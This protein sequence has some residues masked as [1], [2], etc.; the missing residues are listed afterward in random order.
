MLQSQE[1][2][3]HSSPSLIAQTNLIKG[4]QIKAQ[5]PRGEIESPR[6]QVNPQ[7]SHLKTNSFLALPSS[8]PFLVRRI[9]ASTDLPEGIT[10]IKWTCRCGH[11]SHDDFP[12]NFERAKTL[13][14]GFRHSK[15]LRRVEITNKRSGL[16][17]EWMLLLHNVIIHPIWQHISSDSS[18][19]GSSSSASLDNSSVDS[20]SSASG[21]N[22]P[23]LLDD[24][25]DIGAI[26]L[27]RGKRKFVLNRKPVEVNKKHF[28]HVCIDIGRI[29]SL[30]VIELDPQDPSSDQELFRRL[31]TIH[32]K[33]LQRG[34]NL[35]LK[36]QAIRFVQ[37]SVFVTWF[38]MLDP[39]LSE[40]VNKVS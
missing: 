10:R 37:V 16:L 39:K 8:L 6:Q 21:S 24:S 12:L 26:K 27:S 34:Y 13:E 19:P 11:I 31:K 17:Y 1:P 28:L 22:L 25:G 9:F 29:K 30:E 18:N 32:E 4:T 40:K 5:D 38:D 14:D 3:E 33:Q 15:I 35:F 36:L 7:A 20:Q 23:A 2:E